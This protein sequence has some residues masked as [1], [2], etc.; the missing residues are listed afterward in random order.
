VAYRGEWTYS[1]TGEPVTDNSTAGTP[2][3]VRADALE[4]LVAHL[5]DA[6]DS[7]RVVRL[8][9]WLLGVEEAR[10]WQGDVVDQVVF[11][12]PGVHVRL[13]LDGV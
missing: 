5:K 3:Q 13:Y 2:R 8:A 7:V 10:N 6:P 12:D 9:R 4:S 1:V 11:Y